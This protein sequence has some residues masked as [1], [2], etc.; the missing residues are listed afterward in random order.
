M[1]IQ[2]TKSNPLEGEGEDYDC[3]ALESS[4]SSLLG[5]LDTASREPPLKAQPMNTKEIIKDFV[6]ARQSFGDN[7]LLQT[8]NVDVKS[9]PAAHAV[10]PSEA[11]HMESNS[12]MGKCKSSSSGG[13]TE[14]RDLESENDPRAVVQRSSSPHE[15]H[16]QDLF[17]TGPGL[18]APPTS[19]RP[20]TSSCAS[21]D[22]TGSR[23]SA[24][25]A[26]MPD[27]GGNVADVCRA[28]IRVSI[29]SLS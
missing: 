21:S 3:A 10:S 1:V 8:A 6:S 29:F 11:I 20:S 22:G 4:L 28:S 13:L 26:A 25:S 2:N 19:K 14:G 5:F 16:Q 18:S 27:L 15:Q 24:S 17:T 9:P 12:S 23:S 7:Q